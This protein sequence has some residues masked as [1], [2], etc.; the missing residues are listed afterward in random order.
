[1]ELRE[2]FDIIRR[3]W[4]LPALLALA[5]LILSTL[6]ALRGNA[7][8]KTELRLAVSTLPSMDQANAYYDPVYFANLSSEYL[9]DD[10]G[11]IL[12][13]DTFGQDISKELGY[14]L[15]PGTISSVTRAR[16]THRLID[17]TI[18][19]PT[20]E[21]GQAIGNAM[22]KILNDSG[23]TSAYLR[24][25]DAYKA[26]VAVVNQPIVTRGSGLAL[27]GA[28]IALR[29]L[30]GLL[31]GLGLAFLLDYL[32]QTVRSRRELERDLGLTVLGEIPRARRG[33]LA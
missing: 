18:T 21:M 6:V 7:A 19:T 5:A 20:A 1:M 30:L 12:Q 27:L 32:D 2:Y 24:V 31:L 11:E 15:D 28:E 16:K 10:L 4:W 26:Q 29:T 22:V 33:A 23:R 25:L 17:V 13:S 3:R 8:F 14:T 9:A